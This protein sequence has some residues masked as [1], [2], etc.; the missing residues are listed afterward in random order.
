MEASWTH[1]DVQVAWFGDVSHVRAY[2]SSYRFVLDGK[3]G[4][5]LDVFRVNGWFEGLTSATFTLLVQGNGHAAA[6]AKLST[7]Q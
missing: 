6:V 4:E 2:C 5:A 3:G 1:V 7:W